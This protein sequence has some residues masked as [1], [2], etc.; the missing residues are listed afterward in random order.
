MRYSDEHSLA[1][2]HIPK[3]AGISVMKSLE[4]TMRRP[5]AERELDRGDSWA[6]KM[7][8]PELGYIH[9]AHLPV[10][11]LRT[12]FPATYGLIA[13]GRSFAILRDPQARFISAV[14]QR[15][16]EF[17]DV[18]AE[19]ITQQRIVEEAERTAEWLQNL[20]VFCDREF[21][22]FAPQLWFVEDGTGV[23]GKGQPTTLFAIERLDQ[24]E[25]WLSEALGATIEIEQHHVSYSAKNEYQSLHKAIA[26]TGRTMVPKA[27]RKALTPVLH[28]LP[29]Y[30]KSSTKYQLP[31]H[32]VKFVNSYYEKDRLLHRRI[33][34]EGPLDAAA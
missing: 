9:W 19:E 29:M 7:L 14:G 30:K 10:P 17:L 6:E 16:R 12:H 8:H 21:I 32:L 27:V 24:L 4:E 33:L 15:L 11:Y 31:D 13:S 2:I 22:H 20:E 1:F 23:T 18:K 34:A 25:A 28:K 5:N 3:C 26:S